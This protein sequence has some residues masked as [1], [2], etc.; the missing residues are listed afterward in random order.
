[1]LIG[2]NYFCFDPKTK[3]QQPLSL[4]KTVVFLF[5]TKFPLFIMPP[6][7]GHGHRGDPPIKEKREKKKEEEKKFISHS[8][9][10]R[11]PTRRRRKN[12]SHDFGWF[13]GNTLDGF[14][15]GQKTS[16]LLPFP[17]T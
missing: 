9:V 8:E 16:L 5:P 12:S 14:G 6:K 17:P 13:R 2:K 4:V 1:V 3:Q 7:L 15:L 10:I 11:Q